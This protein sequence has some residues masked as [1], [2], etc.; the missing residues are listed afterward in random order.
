[1]TLRPLQPKIFS[2]MT[3]T[4]E[5]RDQVIS[6]WDE[7]FPKI[8]FIQEGDSMLAGTP[9][10]SLVLSVFLQSGP[11]KPLLRFI[12]YNQ[13]NPQFCDLEYCVPDWKR[14][15]NWVRDLRE[16]LD[17]TIVDMRLWF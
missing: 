2:S 12:F 13:G 16:R 9:G 8:G 15:R 3:L 1:V 4:D 5:M 11:S 17:N 7:S 14:L 6:I 10:R